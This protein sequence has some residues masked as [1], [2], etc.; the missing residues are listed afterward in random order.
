MVAAPNDPGRRWKVSALASVSW[1]D[2]TIEISSPAS[3]ITMCSDTERI[4]HILHS[5]ATAKSIG[6]VVASWP[7]RTHT[8]VIGCIHKLIDAGVLVAETTLEPTL[9]DPK[10]LAYHQRSRSGSPVLDVAPVSAHIVAATHPS[11]I[12]LDT[13][14]PPATREFAEVLTHRRSVRSWPVHEIDRRTLSTLLWMSA[15][16]RPDPSLRDHEAPVSRPYPSGGAVYSLEVYPVIGPGAVTSLGSGVYRYRPDLHALEVLAT[17]KAAYDPF[18]I[19]AAQA[20]E[21]GRPP[22][23]LIISS[24]I[25]RQSKHYYHIAYSLVLKEAGALFQTLYLVCEY[26]GLTGCALGGGSPDSLLTRLTGR[27]ILENPVVGEF[28]LG[29][30]DIPSA[31]NES[32]EAV[33]VRT[34]DG[35]CRTPKGGTG[36]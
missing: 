2:G 6:E 21:N 30:R 27:S 24:Q 11:L 4:L 5:F 9:W 36:H 34:R 12:E 31:T 15:A 14:L 7:V 35:T 18:L 17:D 32:G 22:I 25:A 29:P 8:E 3:N 16:N 28:A 19:A 1:P 13:P 20:V 33:V 26:L 10:A 23:V